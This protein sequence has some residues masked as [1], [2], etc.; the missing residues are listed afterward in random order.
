MPVYKL[1]DEL[2]FPYPEEAEAD[3]LL[4][5]GGDL[6]LERLLLA[7]N[8]RVPKSLNKVVKKGIFKIT[9]D[10]A[11]DAVI[12]ECAQAKRPD[13]KG[14]WIV[15]DMISAYGHLHRAGFAHSVESWFEG[16]LVGGL[17]GVSLGKAF[18]GESMF[19][20]IKNASQVAFVHIVR[21]LQVWD[22]DMID[23]QITT[24][25]L[26]RFG[27]REIPRSQF[28]KRLSNALQHE[29]R[30]GRWS[31]TEEPFPI[32]SHFDSANAFE[33]LS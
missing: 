28:L 20:R 22:F 23:C 15:D 32:S 6:S 10:Q 3:G 19:Y 2:I 31:F 26:L 12:R 1:P 25:H 21:L 24:A 16:E 29:T 9:L 33:N 4:A 11:F 14:T 7:Y 17:Y 8:L 30:R 18:F 5:V 27:T 13:E